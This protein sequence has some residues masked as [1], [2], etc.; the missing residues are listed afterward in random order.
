[1]PEHCW[2]TEKLIAAKSRKTYNR[3]M[4]VRDV[5]HN[6]VKNALIKDG[7]T[8]TN[9]PLRLKY[10][11]VNLSVDLG[12]ERT[13]AAERHGE[14]IAVEIKSFL[15]DSTI[16]DLKQALGQFNLYLTY[17]KLLKPE[18]K[19]WLAISEIAFNELFSIEGIEVVFEQNQIPLIIVETKTE[20]IIKWIS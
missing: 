16:N 20:E 7:W 3:P 14:K 9:D 8:I 4:A 12:A 18:Y 11:A 15:N 13:L 1:M 2:M 6:A 17:L 5:I 19:L 10:K